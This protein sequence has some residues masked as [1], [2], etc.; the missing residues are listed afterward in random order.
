MKQHKTLHEIAQEIGL[1]ALDVG[2]R[3]GVNDDLKLIAPGVDFF[4]FEPD[5]I[6]CNKLNKINNNSH[7][8]SLNFIPTALGN[9]EN[10]F[11]L[12]LYRQRGCSSKLIARK[13]IAKL[14][15]REKYYINDGIVSVPT[16]RL[17]DVVEEFHICDPAYMKIDVQGMEIDV[18]QGAIKTISESIVCIRTEV[19]FFPMYEGLPLFAEID[20]FLRRY[21]FVPMTFLEIHEWRRSTRQKLPNIDRNPMPY[22]KGQMIHGD[23]LYMLS[24]EFFSSLDE[25]QIKR[26]IRL[27]IISVCYDLFDHAEVI[28][29]K[30]NIRNY[31]RNI[32]NEDPLFILHCLSQKKA[33]KYIGIN[34]IIRRICNKLLC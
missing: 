24:P 29:K 3:R 18:F 2:A 11:D 1:V 9:S 34:K 4:G 6:E 23:I 31:C 28:F 12:N 21:G 19:N 33:Q 16:K 30:P 20:Q 13:D 17:D 5:A 32:C 27:G 26:Q 10:N 14:F 15:S 8:K 22:S 25:N 7:W